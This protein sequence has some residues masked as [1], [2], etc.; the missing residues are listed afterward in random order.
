MTYYSKQSRKYHRE[1]RCIGSIY[2]SLTFTSIREKDDGRFYVTGSIMG[3]DKINK[4]FSEC[5]EANQRAI[6]FMRE[7]P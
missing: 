6:E 7:Y 3:E 5:D 4:D 1:Y 2:G